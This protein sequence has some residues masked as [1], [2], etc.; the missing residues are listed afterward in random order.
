MKISKRSTGIL[1]YRE[2]N[3]RMEFL[4]VHPGGP[5]W[6][7][8][9]L[10][11]WTIPK[12]EYEEPEVPLDAA[13]REFKEETGIELQGSFIQLKPVIQKGGKEVSA[14]AIERDIDAGAIRSNSFEMEWPPKSGKRQSFP[15]IDKASWFSFE[16]AMDK[17]NPAQAGFI[18]ELYEMGLKGSLPISRKD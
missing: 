2:M 16:E 18:E 6:K 3:R 1:L 14:W 17:I 15:E 5:F 13:I 11:A 10:G 9:D 8:K 4:L 12:G 7:N